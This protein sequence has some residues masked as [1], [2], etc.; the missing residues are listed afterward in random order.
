MSRKLSIRKTRTQERNLCFLFSFLLYSHLLLTFPSSSTFGAEAVTVDANGTVLNKKPTKFPA[1]G[2]Y[3][4]GVEVTGGGITDGDKGDITVSASGATF[5]ID[6]GAVSLAKLANM[7]TASVIGRSAP[8]TGVPQ[9]LSMSALKS[10]LMLTIADVSG[11]S[12]ALDEKANDGD[13]LHIYGDETVSGSKTF[14]KDGASS[15]PFDG[16]TPSGDQGVVID[17]KGISVTSYGRIYLY[18]DG[19][20]LQ[21]FLSGNDGIYIGNPAYVGGHLVV[22]N[23]QTQNV[24]GRIFNDNGLLSY[25]GDSPPAASSGANKTTT[26]GTGAIV[27][28]ITPTITGL[29]LT[30]PLS[31]G[32]GGT[33]S[34]TA[35]GALTNFGGTTV[36][37]NIFTLAN[38]SAITFPRINADNTVTARSSSQL[39]SDLAGAPIAS[40]ALTGTPTAPTAAA[41]TNTTQIATTAFVTTAVA[42]KTV[43]T[44]AST[45]NLLQGDGSGNATSAGLAANDVARLSVAN[46]TFIAPNIGAATGTSLQFTDLTLARDGVNMLALRNGTNSQV[47]NVYKT[48]TDA[49]NYIRY[50]LGWNSNEFDIWTEGT[51][52][53][54]GTNADL[55][56][57]AAGVLY[58]SGGGNNGQWRISTSGFFQA[59]T[60]NTYDIGASGANRPRN[61]YIGTD[62]NFGGNL[63]ASGGTI[64]GGSSGLTVLGNQATGTNVAGQNTTISGGLPTGNAAGGAILFA[65][66]NA[67]GSSGTTQ[68]T[69]QTVGGFTAGGKFYVGANG[70]PAKTVRF[71][72]ATLSGGTVTVSDSNVTANTLIIPAAQDNSTTTAPRISGRTVGT[73]FTISAGA[74][75]NGVVGYEM[76]EP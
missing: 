1:H 72:T 51:G 62:G 76:I 38:P 64:T 47:L 31:V 71:G 24:P 49:S 25:G 65:V 26:T 11:L 70:T 14:P 52:T 41:A 20:V 39:L 12:D 34:A 54:A 29:S 32:S 74:A 73:S 42:N 53:G 55:F 23:L 68:N 13:V 28:A 30:S 75:D 48:Y 21:G 16:G 59:Q 33:G 69:K 7:A 63:T 6:N 58:L 4:N 43:P 50:K 56:L 57:K 22:F 3:V 60:D 36:G 44:I 45:T 27:R 19:P 2:L 5:S 35:S 67:P 8:G 66:S 37:Q 15:D 40:P 9:I 46:Q 10:M 17:G 61:I 18:D